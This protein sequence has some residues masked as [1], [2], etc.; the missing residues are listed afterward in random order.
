MSILYKQFNGNFTINS[1][2]STSN[3]YYSPTSLYHVYQ[4]ISDLVGLS[5]VGVCYLVYVV[6]HLKRI[7]VKGSSNNMTQTTGVASSRNGQVF[8]N[9]NS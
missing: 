2:Y 9:L 5:I 6:I 1:D 3:N 4:C 8:V 7:T